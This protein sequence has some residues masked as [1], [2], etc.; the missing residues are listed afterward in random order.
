M[1]ASELVQALN[2]LIEE[3]GDKEAYYM[4]EDGRY[5]RIESTGTDS[6]NDILLHQ[7]SD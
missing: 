2:V 6:D 4:D 1:K 3:H 5:Y 7:T